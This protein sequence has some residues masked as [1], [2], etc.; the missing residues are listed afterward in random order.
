M[1]RPQQEGQRVAEKAHVPI[2]IVVQIPEVVCVTLAGL[3][4]LWIMFVLTF[5]DYI[6][7]DWLGY[8]LSWLSSGIGPQ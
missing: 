3:F 4:W 7:R 2:P 5:A 1:A 8:R 6:S